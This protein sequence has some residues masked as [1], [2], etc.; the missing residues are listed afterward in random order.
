MSNNCMDMDEGMAILFILL[1]I[2]LGAVIFWFIASFQ[3]NISKETAYDLCRNITGNVNVE[4][5]SLN[6][7]LIC[8]IPSY[9]STTNIIVRKAG[10]G[11]G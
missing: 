6:W 10:E 8:E 4:A 9:D 11:R 7:K 2:G 5:S 3:I 1:G